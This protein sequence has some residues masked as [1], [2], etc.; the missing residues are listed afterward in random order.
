MFDEVTHTVDWRIFFPGDV[1]KL[2]SPTQPSSTYQTS[3]VI[4]PSR[5]RVPGYVGFVMSGPHSGSQGS[6]M[7]AK[8]L[9]KSRFM[10]RKTFIVLLL[11]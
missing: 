11:F 2:L 10:G 6:R 5:G 7:S 4:I 9:S 3:S 1:T 8:K